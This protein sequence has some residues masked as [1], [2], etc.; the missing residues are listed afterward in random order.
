MPISS[1]LAE[2]RIPSTTSTT[3]TITKV[4]TAAYAT[5]APTAISWLASCCDVALEQAGERWLDRGRGEHARRNGAEHAADA[6][7]REHVE[8][9]ID[10]Q[11]RARSSVAL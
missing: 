3:L 11:A 9:V 4:E 2:T 7:D 8:R 1:S 6:V 5:V 10:L